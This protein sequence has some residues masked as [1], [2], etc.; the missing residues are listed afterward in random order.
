MGRRKPRRDTPR[1]F[2]TVLVNPA[3]L[4]PYNSYGEPKFVTY[5]FYFDVPFRCVDCGKE[6]VWT[7][8]QQK[9][10]YEVAKGHVESTA[11][12]CRP[13]RRRERERREQARR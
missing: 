12:R 9:W 6:E 5:G 2:G 8:T 7:A 13:C 3:A 11:I 4:A 1:P 10:W